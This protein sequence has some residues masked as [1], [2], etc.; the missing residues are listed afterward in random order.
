MGE[1][2]KYEIHIE[3]QL[4]RGDK[5][6]GQ[7]WWWWVEQQG[8]FGPAVVDHGFAATEKRARRKA[9]R[10]VSKRTNRQNY[11]YTVGTEEKEEG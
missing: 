8:L 2:V 4:S 5:L 9:E 7:G 10:A 3:E 1:A 6:M 11:S